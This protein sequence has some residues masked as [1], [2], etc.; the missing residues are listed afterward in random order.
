M[1]A[2]E[3]GELEE[4]AGMI[5]ERLRALGHD[6]RLLVL[7]RLV[8]EGEVTAGALTG[9]GGLS[10]SALSQHLA[11][12]RDDGIVTFRREGQTLWCRI[13][14][15]KIEQLMGVLFELYCGERA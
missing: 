1:N 3:I 5:A 8:R 11:R 13:A 15:A 9:I 4:K 7:C 6:A 2:T 12:M 10:Q 14:D